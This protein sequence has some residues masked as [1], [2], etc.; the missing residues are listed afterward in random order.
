MIGLRAAKY[1]AIGVVISYGVAWWFEYERTSRVLLSAQFATR[2]SVQREAAYAWPVPPEQ[3]PKDISPP[4]LSPDRVSVAVESAGTEFWTFS[5]NSNAGWFQIDEVAS[6]WPRRCAS[7][8]SFLF[9]GINVYPTLPMPD[10]R[11]WYGG[12]HAFDIKQ[13]AHLPKLWPIP[14][15]LPLKPLWGGLA[16]NVAIYGFMVWLLTGGVIAVRRSVRR[17]RNQCEACGCPCGVSPVCTEC[18]RACGAAAR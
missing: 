16:I 15:H 18:G 13:P 7:R 9:N 4:T 10:T 3:L 6:G 12:W 14:V 2:P 11:A 8:V 17:R 1:A 5:E